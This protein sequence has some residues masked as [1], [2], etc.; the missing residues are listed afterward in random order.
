[1]VEPIIHL[2]SSDSSQSSGSDST[3]EED[4][5]NIAGKKKKR[6]RSMLLE[7]AKDCNQLIN[8]VNTTPQRYKVKQPKS[9]PIK[10]LK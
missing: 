8:V 9:E 5:V 3:S 2:S 4:E 1:V 6:R 7:M 10:P